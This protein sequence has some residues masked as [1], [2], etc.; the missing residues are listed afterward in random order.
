MVIDFKYNKNGEI[1]AVDN[2]GKQLG[3]IW[4]MGDFIE[5]PKQTPEQI[6]RERK[7]MEFEKQWFAKHPNA[8]RF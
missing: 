6:E 2:N 1:V 5:E 7:R 3:H 8:K 4:T